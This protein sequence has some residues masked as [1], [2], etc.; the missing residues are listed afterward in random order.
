MY[1]YLYLGEGED[2]N[3]EKAEKEMD[4][5]KLGKFLSSAGQVMAVLLEE[6][7]ADRV[8]SDL[9]RK[10]SNI[11]VSD[12]YVEL[13]PMP[14]LQGRHVLAS[15]F[16]GIQTHLLLLAY[17]LSESDDLLAKQGAICVWNVNEPSQP[18]K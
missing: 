5:V 18:H 12:A 7:F 4:S 8:Q 9:S 3:T 16:S 1:L 17:S 15:R 13:S 14:L 2:E 10:Q 11:C 6:D